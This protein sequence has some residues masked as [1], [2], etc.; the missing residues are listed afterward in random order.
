V[1]L[2]HAG[3]AD[4]NL[5][6]QFFRHPPQQFFRKIHSVTPTGSFVPGDGAALAVIPLTAHRTLSGIEWFCFH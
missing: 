6:L 4:T 5:V 1:E 2:R 3:V